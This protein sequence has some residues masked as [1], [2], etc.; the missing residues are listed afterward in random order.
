MC[1]FYR[2][3]LHYI[4][5]MQPFER[6]YKNSTLTELKPHSTFLFC[7]IT[8]NSSHHIAYPLKV[9]VLYLLYKLP[10]LQALGGTV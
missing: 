9:T 2:Y 8:H 1:V 3:N 4:F 5:L 6:S 10:S 7:H